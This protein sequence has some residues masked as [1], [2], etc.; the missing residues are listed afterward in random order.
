MIR[1][2][3]LT[4]GKGGKGSPAAVA[5]YASNKRDQER[6]V[7]YYE[8]GAQSEWI[9]RGA[10][11][12]GLRGEVRQ[13]DMVRV[14]SGIAPDGTDISNRG[15]QT[16]ES[17]RF[18]EELTISAPKSVSIMSVEDRRIVAAHQAAVREAIAYVEKEM[19]YARRGKGGVETEFTGNLLAG[20]FTHEDSRP[21]T[22]TGRVAPHLHDHVVIANMT[23]REDGQWV[24]L[25][26][27]WGHENQ[28]KMTAD[29]IYKASLAR[30][31]QDLGYEIERGKGHD[32]EIQGITREQIEH[33]SPR[34]KAIKEEIGGE[35]NTVSAKARETAQNKTKM[36]KREL[37]ATE[38]RFEW[39]QELR[40][41]GVPAAELRE[42]A[43]A[44]A[45]AGAVSRE[46]MTA[47]QA[48][49]SAIRHLSERDTTFSKDQLRQA[50]LA[51]GLGSVTIEDVDRAIEA[52]V[53]GLLDAGKA[54]GLRAE[55]FTTKA[56]SLREAEILARAREGKGQA[57]AIIGKVSK[58]PESGDLPSFTQEEL[59]HGRRT[60]TIPDT[61][62]A[63]PLSQ[64]LLRPMSELHLDAEQERADRG[65]LP[66][67]A[68][69]GRQGD[70]TLRRDVYGPEPAIGAV[71]AIIE[72]RE[73][74]QGFA[75]SQ[76][77][78]AAVELALTS[79]DRHIG[80]VGA[81]GAGKTTSM[82]LIVEEYKKAGYEVIGVAPSAAAATELESAGCDRTQTL[83]SA[84]LEK[85]D[86]DD[87]RPRLYVLD[88]A[89]MVSAKDYDAFYRKADAEGAR[90]LG[91]GDPRQLQSV[92]AGTAFKQL[93]E[94]GAIDYVRIDEIQRQK[95]PHL[96]E[97]A[98]SFARGDAERG[99]E[100]ARPYMRQVEDKSKLVDT[101]AEAYLSL[102]RD[103]R[104]KTLLLVGTN[105][106]R[107][108][109][110]QKVRD[111][112][113]KEGTLGDRAVTVAALDKMDLSKEQV[114]K[115]ANYREDDKQVV[116]AIREKGK[117][118]KSRQVYY[119]VVDT[120]DDKLTLRDRE[121]PNR[122]TFTLD[123]E[124]A[125]IEG[126]F[127]ERQIE[128]R[129]GEKLMFRQNDKERGI[130]NG[131]IGLVHVSRDG[132]AWAETKNGIIEL[133]EKP[134]VMDYAYART[135]HS[136]Q[137]ATVE[138]AIVVGEANR[139]ATAEAAYVAC[140]REKQGL[141][142]ITNDAEKLGQVWSRF[143]ERQAALDAQ[144]KAQR[145]E[146]DVP[147]GL[148]EIQAARREAERALELEPQPAR[149]EPQPKQQE[150]ERQRE[151][152]ER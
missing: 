137:G 71:A 11:I 124:K 113:I 107:Q 102:S 68:G 44:R 29:A 96:R 115:A 121:N 31:L 99:V 138:H 116:V 25:K 62:E 64:H 119:D 134:Q 87:K 30:A 21:D 123:P 65:L 111:G 76:G 140:S 22:E 89:G 49:Q 88:E 81:A 2:T 91:V 131:D 52:R 117:D 33:F 77:Q 61:S 143:S 14:L 8:H 37:S 106:T 149:A 19:V 126:A 24:A 80:I 95:D 120:R 92:E 57:E 5:K 130:T 145:M 17:R 4:S 28:K 3:H 90:T 43:E 78:R 83:A 104:E 146:L 15:G 142:I 59:S 103:E 125:R 73:K 147:R 100:L 129:D 135:V 86:Q 12:A 133:D 93:L 141:D 39:R 67:D 53:G 56:A 84:L 48:I 101:A 26:L 70:G 60:I 40:E 72:A 152:I 32:F 128:L 45:A 46:S 36:K 34:S 144:Q 94:T 74:A 136:S 38:Q 110:N 66:S 16:E 42:A 7:G 13:E 6:A 18:G 69:A 47:E 27:D 9:G 139:V 35:R 58:A 1:A 20:R 98:M 108:E 132:K 112:L 82:A 55:Q 41:A 54:K 148:G 75:F 63:R 105:R 79:E 97:I 10:E 122:A 150:T 51:A 151:G 85:R 118:G 127:V 114:K 23:R 109:I 50:A